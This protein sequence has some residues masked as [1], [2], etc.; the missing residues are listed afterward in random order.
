MRSLSDLE[1]EDRDEISPTEG[2]M[3]LALSDVSRSFGETT[4]FE[5][6]SLSVDRGDVLALIG[7]SG[8]GKSTLL[9]TFALFEEPQSGSVLADGMRMWECTTRQRLAKRRSIGMVFQE[10][11]LFDATVQRNVEYGLN[12]RR[13]WTDRLLKTLRVSD[14]TPPQSVRDALSLVGMEP[15][16]DEPV[17]SLSGGE[18]QRV[19]FARALSYEPTYMLFDEPTSDLDPRNTAVI[20]DAITT[21]TARGIGAVIATHD[22]HQAQRIADRVALLFDGDIVE[23]GPTDQLFT[24]PRDERTRKFISGELIY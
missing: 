14:T 24:E 21:A 10:P 19:A 20:E 11:N 1:V 7:P 18:A 6:I 23:C 16:L 4:V 3:T 17:T 15:F 9:R 13:S 5:N 8:A 12:V 22:M 2:Q